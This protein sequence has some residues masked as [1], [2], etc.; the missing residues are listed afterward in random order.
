MWK[1]FVRRFD[2][3]DSSAAYLR[4]QRVELYV[5]DLKKWFSYTEKAAEQNVQRTAF[6]AFCGGV[7]FGMFAMFVLGAL[8]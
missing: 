7:I 8:L 6:A 2:I 1:N 3:D 4:F 5:S